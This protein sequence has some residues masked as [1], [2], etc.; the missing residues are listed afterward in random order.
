MYESFWERDDRRRQETVDQETLNKIDANIAI[1][2]GHRLG[3]DEEHI[4]GP[5]PCKGCQTYAQYSQEIE[6]LQTFRLGVLVGMGKMRIDDAIIQVLN[7][8]EA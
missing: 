4:L 3:S 6:R 7:G 8:G 5:A 1:C 2:R